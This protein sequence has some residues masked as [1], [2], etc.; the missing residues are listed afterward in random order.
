MWRLLLGVFVA[1]ALAGPAQAAEIHGDIVL[2][3]IYTAEPGE[4]NNVQVSYGPGDVYVIQDSGATITAGADCV[5]ITSHEAHCT[6]ASWLRMNLSLGDQNDVATM[7]SLPVGVDFLINAGA[8]N[9][10]VSSA[11]P[12]GTT[13]GGEGNDTMVMGVFAGS[14]TFNG[15]AGDD[16][17]HG[18]GFF[19]SFSGGDGDDT[20][21][22]SFADSLQGGPGSD[23]IDLAESGLGQTIDLTGGSIAGSSTID[24]TF[25][26]VLAG[27]GDD[28]LLGNASANHLDGGA[29]SDMLDG[30]F[31]ADML[32]GGAGFDVA[33]YSDR[34]SGVVV[35]LDGTPTSGNGDDGP[36]LSRDEIDPD[37]E[38]AFGGSGSDTFIGSASDNL[39]NGGFGADGFVGGPGF[40]AVDYSDRTADVFVVLDGTPTSGNA[41]DGPNPGRDIVDGS[42]E[43]IFGGDGDDTLIG[44]ASDNL[45]DGGF[46]A[47]VYYGGSGNDIADYS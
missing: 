28:V 11:K 23:T 45:F 13:F 10:A 47:D 42:M 29:G 36:D 2:G 18:A 20:V 16:F 15:E 27:S 32:V 3:L 8:G 1:L 40:D 33:D 9:D 41:D 22:P 19:D 46:G 4:T 24:G 43:D 12:S 7:T 38:G 30:R 37:V 25:E 39:F 26:N 17:F 31:G 14:A 6:S 5:V 21:D 35:K 44:N 34:T